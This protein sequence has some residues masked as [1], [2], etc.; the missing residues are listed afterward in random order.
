LDLYQ[1]YAQPDGQ[2]DGCGQMHPKLQEI[3]NFRRPRRKRAALRTIPVSIVLATANR[4][5]AMPN[6]YA[7]RSE[8]NCELFILTDG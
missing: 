2:R 8:P 6:N 1:I 4:L 3:K 5:L 7:A